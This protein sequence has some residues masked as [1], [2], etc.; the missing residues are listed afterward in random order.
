M[1]TIRFIVQN[2]LNEK[3]TVFEVEGETFDIGRA[4][5]CEVAIDDPYSSRHHVR[6]SSSPQGY[7]IEELGSNPAL[8]NDA[9]AHGRVL[10]HGDILQIANTRLRVEL[11][12]AGDGTLILPSKLFDPHATLVWSDPP[13]MLTVVD[14]PQQGQ[15][16][17][18]AG[19][20][21]VIG[22]GPGVDWVLDDPHV[23][24]RHIA[25]ERQG[26]S[27]YVVRL[28]GSDTTTFNGKGFGRERLNEGDHIA[29]P[30]YKLCFHFAPL[31]QSSSTGEATIV[32]AS[33]A[34]CID[35]QIEHKTLGARLVWEKTPGQSETFSI[36]T[37][38]IVIGRSKSCDLRLSG[39]TV[40]RT[41]AALE[42]RSDGFYVLALSS[43]N[44]LRVNQKKVHEQRLYAA[45][46]I[47]IGE[48]LLTFVSDR[49]EDERP[50]TQV[51]NRTGVP[52]SVMAVIVVLTI[53]M[54]AVLANNYLLRPWL[55]NTTLTQV[56]GML[57]EDTKQ[58]E[59][60]IAL[61]QP[62]LADAPSPTIAEQARKLLVHAVRLHARQ[63]AQ[64][65][66]ED[67]Q[68][69]LIVHLKQYGADSEFAPVWEDLDI[70][71]LSLGKNLEA[72]GNDEAA[73]REYLGINNNSPHFAEAAKAIN[74]L[75]LKNQ[76]AK[77]TP[78]DQSEGVAVLL[79]RAEESFRKRQ[80]L[81][82]PNDNAYTLFRRIL[83]QEPENAA[84]R[85]RIIE[86]QS[87]YRA[88]AEQA[89]TD[90]KWEEGRKYY[91]RYAVVAPEDRDAIKKSAL[92]RSPAV[93]PGTA[94]A[95]AGSRRTSGASSPP[96]TPAGPVDTASTPNPKGGVAT[97]GTPANRERVKKL[98]D[99]S[100]VDSQWIMEFLF[101]GKNDSKEAETPW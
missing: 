62:L 31:P 52:H 72:K 67:A 55:A 2:A 46:I 80:F 15:D 94:T 10:S 3:K 16:V 100:N 12:Q 20:R 79:R 13:P 57:E 48:W 92:C 96:A 66:L 35:F 70:L 71:H 74:A 45:D 50:V 89:C 65:K 42:K 4:S 77:L 51:I 43:S 40:S 88:R 60:A 44:P 36:T 39:D 95:T 19:E 47:Q 86:I 93:S 91:E 26:K 23:S 99:N 28:S 18:L 37:S 98:L 90:G 32:S 76:Q 59:P 7:V 29:I 75:W 33:N 63:L 8:L 53:A 9:A 82:P 38:R 34:T 83:A 21:T 17:A 1:P 58:Y 85:G 11:V 73:M 101:K 61:L 49:T 81:T 24:R 68:Q 97:G 22:R 54:G 27:F 56:R 41:H 30:P 5:E 25:I 14:G 64:R 84:A 69:F 87:F 78:A 6:I